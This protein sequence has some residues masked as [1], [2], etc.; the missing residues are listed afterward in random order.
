[1]T[2]PLR[3]S[4]DS[5]RPG[6]EQDIAELEGIDAAARLVETVSSLP[7]TEQVTVLSEVHSRLQSALTEIGSASS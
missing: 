6:P 4:S 5:P 7:L 1:V 2:T 3:D